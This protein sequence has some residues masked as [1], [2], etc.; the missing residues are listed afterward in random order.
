MLAHKQ[1]GAL[2]VIG[3]IERTWTSSIVMRGAGVQLQPFENAMSRILGGEPVG[4]ALRDFYDRYV[5][6]STEITQ[7]TE[8]KR[9]G[10]VVPDVQIARL[11][12]Q[13]N[14]AEGYVV[15]GDPA[16]RLRPELLA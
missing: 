7:R 6:T 15:L 2:A 12:L 11:W 8:D 3:H 9:F 14:D 16:A 13:R 10:I 1:G 5:V 4:H